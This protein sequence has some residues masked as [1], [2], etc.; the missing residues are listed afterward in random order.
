[1]LAVLIPANSRF[2]RFFKQKKQIS[3]FPDVWE[4]VGRDWLRYNAVFARSVVS[5]AM[6]DQARAMPAIS[7]VGT[8]SFN[9]GRGRGS[10]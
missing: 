7:F 5:V 10:T 4:R 3:S 8:S 1:M 9:C 6:L 2:F